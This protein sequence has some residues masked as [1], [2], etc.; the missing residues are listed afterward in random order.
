MKR[1]DEWLHLSELADVVRVDARRFTSDGVA[2]LRWKLT[3]VVKEGP[4]FRIHLDQR[5]ST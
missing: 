5:R 2:K 4:T 3:G 1:D